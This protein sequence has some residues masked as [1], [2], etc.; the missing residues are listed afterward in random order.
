MPMKFKPTDHSS[1]RNPLNRGSSAKKPDS[2]DWTERNILE[3]AREKPGQR[4]EPPKP[5]PGTVD[6]RAEAAKWA[7][8]RTADLELA[9]KLP[10]LFDPPSVKAFKK[11]L[12]HYIDNIPN[13]GYWIEIDGRS[14]YRERFTCPSDYRAAETKAALAEVFRDRIPGIVEAYDRFVQEKRTTSFEK[15]QGW[16]QGLIDLRKRGEQQKA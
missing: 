10:A 6:R 8:Q 2:G 11:S 1:R 13:E 16:A 5:R 7:A 3:Y 12:L 9:G 4:S 15:F 14:V